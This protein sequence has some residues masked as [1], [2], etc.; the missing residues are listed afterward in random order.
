MRMLPRAALSLALFSL[1]GSGSVARADSPSWA[2]SPLIPQACEK[3][4]D[5]PLVKKAAQ[6][7]ASLNELGR[8]AKQNV[9]RANALGAAGANDG[10]GQR[11]AFCR[12]AH[13]GYEGVRAKLEPTYRLWADMRA[14]IKTLNLKKDDECTNLLVS[15]TRSP[16]TLFYGL[17]GMLAKSCPSLGIESGQ[18]V[19]APVSSGGQGA[20][21]G[22]CG[23]GVAN[24]I[25]CGTPR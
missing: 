14:S 10:A 17:Q 13:A 12:A 2:L 25:A 1:L 21:G 15:N 8:G 16:K 22:D 24:P 4:K 9:D 7:E 11:N 20:K 6:E 5:F 18:N 23:W 3:Y 19:P